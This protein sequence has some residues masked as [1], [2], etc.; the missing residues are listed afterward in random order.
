[1]A[2]RWKKTPTM[3]PLVP[4]FTLMIRERIVG[5]GSDGL[6]MLPRRKGG[7][8]VD[9]VIGFVAGVRSD[10]T[11]SVKLSCPPLRRWRAEIVMDGEDF[12]L[13]KSGGTLESPESGLGAVARWRHGEGTVSCFEF[14]VS[15]RR[16]GGERE[17]EIGQKGKGNVPELGL[18]ALRVNG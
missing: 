2:P 1:M 4:I 8:E 17:R 3:Y 12:R 5:G 9:F 10:Q 18:L 11:H 16:R 6:D 13:E 14:R 15:S 7:E